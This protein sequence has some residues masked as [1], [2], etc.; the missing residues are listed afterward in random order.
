MESIGFKTGKSHAPAALKRNFAHNKQ[1]STASA[2][3]SHSLVQ[4]F[5][6]CGI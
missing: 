4:M 1:Q 5:T 2:N 6:N 3:S